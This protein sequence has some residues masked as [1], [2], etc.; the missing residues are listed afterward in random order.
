MELAGFTSLNDVRCILKRLRPVESPP[1][2]F[3]CEGAGARMVA[4]FPVVDVFDQHFAFFRRDA[5]ER[6]SVWAL[7]VENSFEDLVRFCL[8]GNLLHFNV[9]LGG[10]QPL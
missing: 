6:D 5:F 4:A 9:F 7:A 3:A 1:E 8:A 10:P 2:D